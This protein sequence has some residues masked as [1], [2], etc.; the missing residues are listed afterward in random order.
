VAV[1]LLMAPC[2][3]LST[4]TSKSQWV[5]AFTQWTAAKNKKKEEEKGLVMTAG[6]WPLSSE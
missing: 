3:M 2:G 1:R 5:S 6:S 4:K